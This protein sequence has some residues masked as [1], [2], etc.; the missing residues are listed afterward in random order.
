MGHANTIQLPPHNLLEGD[1]IERMVHAALSS[2]NMKPTSNKAVNITIQAGV[3][4]VGSR[5]IVV[6]GSDA[7]TKDLVGKAQAARGG[8]G[9]DPS[10]D[11]AR[12][13]RAESVSFPLLMW[14]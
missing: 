6:F 12:K 10:A 7:A 4:V 14:W 2:Y 5:N 11:T 9:T 1:N 3:S 8:M 13:R